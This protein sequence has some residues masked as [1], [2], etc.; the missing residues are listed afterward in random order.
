[1]DNLGNR[2]NKINSCMAELF[3]LYRRNCKKA[4]DITK[5]R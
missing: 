4:S 1:M 2:R 3:N 5:K